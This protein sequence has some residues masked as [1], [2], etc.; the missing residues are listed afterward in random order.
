MVEGGERAMSNEFDVRLV[1]VNGEEYNFVI[2]P[3]TSGSDEEIAQNLIDEADRKKWFYFE[4]DNIFIKYDNVVS[5]S[6][7]KHVPVGSDYI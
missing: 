2:E 1:D 4:E 6:V 3:N 5:V 7:S